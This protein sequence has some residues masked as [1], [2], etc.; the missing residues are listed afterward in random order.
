MVRRLAE[1]ETLWE[2]VIAWHG[3]ESSRETR[4]RDPLSAGV[5]LRRRGLSALVRRPS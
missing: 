1:R 3:E 4:G 5:S 2:K